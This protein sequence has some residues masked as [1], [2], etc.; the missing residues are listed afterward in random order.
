MSSPHIE[1][2]SSIRK[3][4]CCLAFVLIVAPV[5]SAQQPPLRPLD[6]FVRKAMRDWEVP[7]LAI[8]VVQ[9]DKIVYLKNFG[10]RKI[11][12]R[13]P[14]DER[15]LFQIGSAT[16]AFTATALGMLVD[17]GKLKWDDPVSTWLKDFRLPTP[18]LTARVTIRDLLSHRTGIGD[19]LAMY[20]GTSLSRRDL[21]ERLQSLDV[22]AGLRERFDYNNLMYV[23]AGEVIRAVSGI[24]WA[25][26][27]R[28]RLFQPLGMASSVTDIASLRDRSNLASGHGKSG[29]PGTVQVLP[30]IDLDAVGPAGGILSNASDMAQWVRFQIGNGTVAG[31]Q[32][33]KPGT[34]N[35]MR[36]PQVFIP[37]QPP[38]SLYFFDN[39]FS[40]YGLGWMLSD[41]HGHQIIQH[42]GLTDAMTSLVAL[43][44]DQGV[45]M[46]VLTNSNF[47]APWM[48]SAVMYQVFDAFL[49]NPSKDWNAEYLQKGK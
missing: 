32:L 3:K 19:N 27:I 33:V 23:A 20:W 24:E 42:A 15:T 12:E 7:G 17:D 2:G 26:F 6:D 43:M 45:G 44:P 10:V 31:R 1:I 35:E 29:T 22:H 18:E 39:V 16:K 13:P 34:M 4:L 21:M 5:A 36:T 11:G 14:I 9:N 48:P 25:D 47:G 46:V 28:Q 49:G 37:R 40:A 38:F 8:V 30:L 41:Y